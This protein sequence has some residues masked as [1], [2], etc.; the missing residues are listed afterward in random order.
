MT[1]Y[2]LKKVLSVFSL[3]MINIV[4]VD[5][6]RTLPLAA[7]YGT[8][9]IGLYLIG[10]IIFFIPT[11]L[12]TAELA[13]TWPKNGGMYI[14][15]KE[16]FGAKTGLLVVYLQWI[17]NIVWYPTILT[18]VA[19][20]IAYL[21][22]P[23]WISNRI[24]I[25][26]TVLIIFWTCTLLNCFGMRLSSYLSALGAILGT[27]LPMFIMIALSL[28]C[29]IQG[30]SIAI[31]L[32]ISG[33]LPAIDSLPELVFATAILYSLIGLEMSAVHASEVNNPSKDYPKALLISASIILVS[34][35]LSSLA[36][37][38][39]VPKNELDIVVGIMQAFE[40]FF[41]DL[42]QPQWIKWIGCS[43]VIGG[44]GGVATWI[45]GPTK[46]LQAAGADKLI[47]RQLQRV[48]RF[49]VP[50]PILMLQGAIGS[51]LSL[52]FIW[53]P[54]VNGAYWLLSAM[55]TQLALI[56][57]AVIFF[58]AIR[59]RYTR[60]N[61]PRVFKIPGGNAGMWLVAGTGGITCIGVIALGF[62][63]PNAVNVGKTWIY[64]A[65]LI[66]GMILILC[67]WCFAKASKV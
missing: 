45:I 49:G 7:S 3:V 58:A 60:S 35:I 29:L 26:F 37:A 2:K 64:E 5:S 11:A 9:L 4:A 39:V 1:S 27:L 44:M 32:N 22:H 25:S 46:G 33:L 61:V 6:I 18:L 57:Y 8:A 59:L 53:M 54:T 62:I 55:A 13:T 12:V 51:L 28:N 15:V 67:P 19:G 23:E 52:S 17:Y 47:P 48:N 63:P 41:R 43:I 24:F 14:W 21:V 34:L 65:L 50:V 38:L 42:N 30:K 66:G 31:D 10:A 36:I 56:M 40:V 16:A 20:T